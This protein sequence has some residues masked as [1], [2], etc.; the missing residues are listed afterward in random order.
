MENPKIVFILKEVNENRDKNGVWDL[1]E[2]Y[3]LDLRKYLAAG[4]PKRGYTWNNVAR[5][6]HGI[7]EIWK[8]REMPKWEFYED[9]DMEK[10]RK[11]TLK[12]ICTMNLKKT[13]G[14]SST[15]DNK[16][17]EIAMCDQNL[18]RKQY[19]LYNPDITI[20]GNT[21]SLFRR[22]MGKDSNCWQNEN[23]EWAWW[24]ERE[25]RKPGKY[26]IYTW[27]PQQRYYPPKQ[28]QKELIDV[29]RKIYK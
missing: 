15:N 10:F 11:E 27:H 17:E 8:S 20:C 24:Y 25:G 19:N 22:V 2:Y 16:L 12:S 7:R 6:V 21:G 1:E 26:V 18:I 4:T 3:D 28:L 23:N 13:P 29:I 9:K 5:W 14:G